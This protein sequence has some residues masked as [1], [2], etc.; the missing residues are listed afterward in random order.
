MKLSLYIIKHC[1]I[2]TCGTVEAFFTSA[3]NGG[4]WSAGAAFWL[5]GK[6]HWMG[7]WVL[8][9]TGLHCVDKR[10]ISCPYQNIDS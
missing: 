8:T 6:N 1:A 7:D 9:R 4:E 3:Q 5:R 2:K 10:E